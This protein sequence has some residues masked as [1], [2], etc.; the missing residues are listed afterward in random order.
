MQL[1]IFPDAT[2]LAKAAAI[3][4]GI[5]IRNSIREHGSARIIA[6]TGASQFKFLDELTKA[7]DIDWARVEMFHLDEYLG[8]PATHPA[9]F[10]KYLLDR[11]IKKTG[12]NRYHLLNGEDDPSKVINRVSAEIRKAPVDIA[13]V[14]VGENGHL[15]FN[16]PPADFETD[17]SYIVVQLDEASRRQQLG[18]N[19][20]KSLNEVPRLAISMT[21][22]QIL[23]S[24]QILCIVPEA[25]KARAVAKCFQGHISPLAPAS[26]LRT[27]PNAF[28]YLDN[29]SASLLRTELGVKRG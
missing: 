2:S 22:R 4:A 25:R 10:Q 3:Q 17:K 14:G 9:S 13:F 16:D 29:D 28:I 20:F 12:I 7:P 23:K 21:I 6:A 8:M 1:K 15:A 11:L 27:H 24:K 19:W 26:I 18:E 5:T